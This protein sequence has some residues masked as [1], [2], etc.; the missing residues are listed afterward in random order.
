M[1]GLILLGFVHQG[2]LIR[3]LAAAAAKGAL[4]FVDVA[5]ESGLRF[6]HTFGADRMR[7]VLMTTGSGA[8]FCD[9]DN[10]GWLDA[11]LVNGSGLDAE[12]NL[13]A[14]SASRLALFRNRGGAGQGVT[15]ENVT[16]AAGLGAPAYGQGVTCADYDGDGLTD[17]YLTNY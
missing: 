14:S 10:D 11:I 8:G 6:R 4:Q 12:G 9:F 3:P 7:N 17:I 1:A 16:L 5:A 13:V 2:V 15:F